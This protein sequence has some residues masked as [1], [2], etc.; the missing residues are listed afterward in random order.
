MS[1]EQ[2]PPAELVLRPSRGRAIARFLFWLA[3]TILYIWLLVLYPDCF[4][5]WALAVVCGLL[6]LA[7]LRRV[8]DQFSCLRLT[9]NGFTVYD[10]AGVIAFGWSDIREFRVGARGR[11]V[12]FDYASGSAETAAARKI[13]VFLAGGD[14]ALPDLYN[15]TA[16]ELADLLN[17]WRQRYGPPPHPPA[18]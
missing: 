11:M 17:E 2:A 16:R 10:R 18:S 1:T 5:M 3:V 8:F 15:M 4:L 13:A 9:A 12:L 6:A 14:G 7:A